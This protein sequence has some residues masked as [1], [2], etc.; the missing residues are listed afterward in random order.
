MDNLTQVLEKFTDM[1]LVLVPFLAALAF[2][3][4]VFGV[5][6][7]IRSAGNENELAKSKNI[8]IWGVIGIFIMFSIWGILIFIRKE[9][10]FGDT[11]GIPQIFIK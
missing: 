11:L 10:G 6:R 5:G 2:V 8:I 7:F 3:S 1:A 4:F 9:F